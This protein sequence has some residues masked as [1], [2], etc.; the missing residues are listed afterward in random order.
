MIYEKETAFLLLLGFAIGRLI[1]GCWNR[2]RGAWDYNRLRS[3]EGRLDLCLA[4][5]PIL[6]LLYYAAVM[7]PRPKTYYGDAL[8]LS[9]LET[10]FS[11]MKLDPL[12]WLFVA[13]ALG[14]LYL[15]LRRKVVPTPFWDALALGGLAYFTAYCCL[16]LSSP[17]YLAP[18]DLIAVLYVGRFVILA[19]TQTSLGARLPIV[20]LLGVALLQCI[21]LSAFWLFQRKNLIH[22]KAGIARA[23]GAQYQIGKAHRLYFPFATSYVVSEFAAYLNY[24]GTPAEGASLESAGLNPVFMVSRAVA[25]DGPCMGYMSLMCHP[26]SRPDQGDLVIVLPDDDASLAEVIPYR[27]PE[28][29]LFS[30]QPYPRIPQWLR[31]FVKRIHIASP[32]FFP[33][34][35]GVQGNSTHTELPDRWLDASVTVW[36]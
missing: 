16:G 15:I 32:L 25:K 3:K 36:K 33:F 2:D 6:F 28:E 19:W 18:V 27:V 13:F 26:G 4:S 21:S 7:H 10:C 35:Q 5:L 8:R 24:Q 22:A 34:G 31:P 9:L 20:V 14:R 23:V 11:Y 12:A 17:Y 1:L 30:Y 29:L